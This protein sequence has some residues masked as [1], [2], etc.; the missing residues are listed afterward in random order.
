[1]QPEQEDESHEEI[2]FQGRRKGR[3]TLG[4]FY[5]EGRSKLAVINHLRQS[6]EQV[7]GHVWKCP[8]YAESRNLREKHVFIHALAC[9]CCETKCGHP[10]AIHVFLYIHLHV[11]A[12]KPNTVIQ[13]Q[14]TC[15]F[16]MRSSYR[17][18]V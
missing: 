17:K 2:F 16:C 8:Q 1:M 9:F 4:G 5:S 12:V 13:P 3:L 18:Y 14:Y 15:I 10:T 7:Q 6:E 11:F